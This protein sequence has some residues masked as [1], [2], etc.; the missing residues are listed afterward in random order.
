MSY[1]DQLKGNNL[2]RLLSGMFKAGA[3][4]L[5]GSDGKIVANLRVETSSPWRHIRSG[6][7]TNC[8]LWKEVLFHEIV[9][10]HLPIEKRFAP[11]GC[12]DCF[13]IVARPRTLEQLFELEKVMVQLDLPSKLGIEIRPTVFANYGSYFY[14][15]GLPAGLECY[16]KV[17]AAV[18][19]SPKLGPDIKVILK[20]GC[21]E[22]E[23]GIGR[24]DEWKVTQEQVAFEL[25]LRERFVD[26]IPVLNQSDLVIN[27][28]HQRW[29]E[30]AYGIADETILIYTDGK[31][32][33][34]DYVTY[35]HLAERQEGEE[36]PKK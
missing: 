32:L 21:T 2:I 8:F 31:P 6:Y 12:Q 25:Y 9:E 3:L 15:R 4:S 13:K 14:N 27:E 7:K 1:Y 10:K 19:A 29:I 11:L 16:K 28:V 5:R 35:H 26:D 22:I 17:R 18:D 20:R 34:P 36:E 33:Y 30:Y 23:H 24:S